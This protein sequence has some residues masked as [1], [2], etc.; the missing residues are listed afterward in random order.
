MV[1][2]IVLVKAGRLIWTG[3]GSRAADHL[4]QRLCGSYGATFGPPVPAE[5]RHNDEHLCR[6]AKRVVERS[7]GSECWGVDIAKTPLVLVLLSVV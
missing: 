4:S 5:Q 7:T 3:L 2:G 6:Y 1:G